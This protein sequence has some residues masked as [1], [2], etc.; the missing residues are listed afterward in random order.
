MSSDTQV[1]G[2]TVVPVKS[3]VWNRYS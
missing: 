1:G 2:G 3:G